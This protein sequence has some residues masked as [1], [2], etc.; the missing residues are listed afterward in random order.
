MVNTAL[1]LQEEYNKTDIK[2][3]LDILDE[4]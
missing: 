2:K 4:E 3:V 1:N